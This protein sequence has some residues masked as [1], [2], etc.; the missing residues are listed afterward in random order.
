MV[1][2]IPVAPFTSRMTRLPESVKKRSPWLSTAT[3]FGA[4]ISAAVAGPPSP[5]L[6]NWPSPA[7]VV[8]TPVRAFTSRMTLLV[9]SAMKTSPLPSTATPVGLVNA[10]L[11]AGPPSPL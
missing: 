6:P 8:M 5:V 1:V 9:L 7:T 11:I 4:A 10:A 2:M 3:L